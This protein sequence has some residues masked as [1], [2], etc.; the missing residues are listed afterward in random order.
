VAGDIAEEFEVTSI[1]TVIAFKHGQVVHRFEGDVD[2][3]HIDGLI[4]ELT[5]GEAEEIRE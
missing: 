4:S 5:D 3:T 2:D 1:P